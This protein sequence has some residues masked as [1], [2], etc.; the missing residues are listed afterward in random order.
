[1]KISACIVKKQGGWIIGNR[2]RPFAYTF[3]TREA[4]KK[5]IDEKLKASGLTMTEF[6]IR[7]ITGKADVQ[8]DGNDGEGN[9]GSSN[10]YGKGD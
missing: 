9:E 5:V 3:R 10:G 7:A 2:T 6:I 1:M 4:E 8:S